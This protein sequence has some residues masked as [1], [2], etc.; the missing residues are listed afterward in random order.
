MKPQLGSET[1]GTRWKLGSIGKPGR[2]QAKTQGKTY[3]DRTKNSEN[4]NQNRPKIDP[5]AKND[6][7]KIDQKRPKS[8]E[9]SV[10]ADFGRPGRSGSLR[11]RGHARD[12]RRPPSWVVLAARLA[13]M[14]AKLTVP[15]A[16]LAVSSARLALLGR[17]QA[18]CERVPSPNPC[19][20]SV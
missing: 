17:C 5:G 2:R 9:K 7:Q 12:G 4:R 19:P 8:D 15:G 10:S 13:V 1:V 20:S 11:G 18:L 16:K 14:G 6:R 3:E